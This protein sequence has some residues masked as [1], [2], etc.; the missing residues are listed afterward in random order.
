[1][2]FSSSQTLPWGTSH[3][4]PFSGAWSPSHGLAAAARALLSPP[5]PASDGAADAPAGFTVPFRPRVTHR[6]TRGPPR[7]ATVEGVCP[8]SQAGHLFRVLLRFLK[9]GLLQFREG[10]NNRTP[11]AR[12]TQ[13]ATS[14]GSPRPCFLLLIAAPLFPPRGV[15]ATCTGSPAPRARWGAAAL[16][17]P[18]CPRGDASSTEADSL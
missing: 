18:G 5:A 17:R 12:C 10:A 4:P 16:R 1:M 11:A 3:R 14:A 15:A 7:G 13:A 9:L 8:L 2:S 6:G